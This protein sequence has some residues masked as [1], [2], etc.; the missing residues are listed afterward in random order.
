MRKQC[1]WRYVPIALSIVVLIIIIY[2]S[3]HNGKKKGVT[4][5]AGPNYTLT[6]SPTAEADKLE[7]VELDFSIGTVRFDDSEL[8]AIKKGSYITKSRCGYYNADGSFA[9]EVE[10]GTYIYANAYNSY[11]M[12]RATCKKNG[13]KKAEFT[14]EC[15]KYVYRVVVEGD[16]YYMDPEELLGAMAEIGI[17]MP[18][19]Q[20]GAEAFC[21]A[22]GHTEYSHGDIWYYD[23]AGQHLSE[24]I[25][26]VQVDDIFYFLD[27]SSGSHLTDRY[28]T[29]R[30]PWG[31]LWARFPDDPSEFTEWDEKTGCQY[32]WA[33]DT[34]CFL[35]LDFDGVCEYE[36]KVK[37]WFLW[38]KLD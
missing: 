12:D 23:E 25:Y 27:M 1:L 9:G 22:A 29:H 26:D 38:K 17:D 34:F 4:D 14:P 36:M 35:D 32:K 2:V 8:T 6:P 18:A 7:Y 37:E 19:G 10:Q 33:K 11:Y 21:M 5:V 3:I 16:F 24:H 15:G 31:K 13:D 30:M 20:A 28:I